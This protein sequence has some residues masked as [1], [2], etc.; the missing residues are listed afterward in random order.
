MTQNEWLAEYKKY[1]ELEFL[2]CSFEVWEIQGSN[3]SMGYAT[4]AI[5]RY[6]GKKRVF[7]GVGPTKNDFFA[8]SD[9]LLGT[10]Q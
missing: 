9:V 8:F 10:L 5:F 1:A 3:A 7:K 6:F 4:H 2:D